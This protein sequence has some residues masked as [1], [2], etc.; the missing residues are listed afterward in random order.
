MSEEGMEHAQEVTHIV[1]VVTCG[2]CGKIARDDKGYLDSL[3][4]D[5]KCNGRISMVIPVG[6]SVRRKT[7]HDDWYEILCDQC[8]ESRVTSDE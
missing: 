8:S 5:A 7:V 3:R 2:M 6:F 1:R 4:I